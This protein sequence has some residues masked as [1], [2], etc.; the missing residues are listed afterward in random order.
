M[1]IYKYTKTYIMGRK[2]IIHEN[3]CVTC[4]NKFNPGKHKEKLN[5]SDECLK[6]YKLSH[7]EERMN[8][9][10]KSI[11]EKYGVN[12]YPEVKN[13][14]KVVKQSKKEKHG[15]ENYNNYKKIKKTL[16]DKYKV[17]SVG[18]LLKHKQFQEKSKTTK[19]E[20]YGNENF[21]NR[22]SAKKTS[23]KKYGY[24]HHL[25]DENILE[26]MVNTNLK[27]H[28]K[29]WTLL[30]DK[31]KENLKLK[32]QEKYNVDYFFESEKHLLVARQ[33]KVEK[34]IE[35]CNNNNLKFDVE[36]YEKLRNKTQSGKLK[37]IKYKIL[38]LKCNKPFLSNFA[39]TPICRFC[40]PIS[41]STIQHVELRDFLKENSIDFIE[42]DR[43]LISPFEIDFLIQ[44]HNLAIELNGNFYHAELSFGKDKN[45]HLNKSI[46]CNLKGIRLIHIF[47][48]EWINKK[49]ILKSLILNAC[50]KIKNKIYARN[51][52]FKDVLYEEKKKFLEENHLQSND[53]SKHNFG[54]YHKGELVSLMT[55][56]SLRLALGNKKNKNGSLELSR[57]CSKTNIQIVGGFEK[58]LKNSILKLDGAQKII[59]YADC[60]FRGLNYEDTVYYKCGF[61]FISTS[62]PSYFYV[63]KNNYLD[64]YHRFAYNKQKLI[65]LFSADKGKTEWKIAQENNMDRLWDCGSMKFEL[66]ISQSNFLK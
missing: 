11:K 39:E 57:F 13:F 34:I 45:Y 56:C 38:C 30:L 10:F 48:D 7:K 51:C 9:T 46:Q 26:K 6:S 22:S 32:N 25:K 66:D 60:R 3:T 65:K 42:N 27:K 16:K 50:Q 47:E 37:Y 41:S 52:E 54:L 17:N 62:K 29:K 44:D 40:N 24:D 64:R 19:K 8:N 36:F 1:Y 5:C 28:N 55:F 20:K 12:S 61:D 35:T 49:K 15:D 23:I 31:S 18:G 14:G 53:Y 2:K 21:N 4:G 43:S 33:M 58:L 59:T 63:F